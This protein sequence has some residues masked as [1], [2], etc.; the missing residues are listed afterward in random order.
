MHVT[1]SGHRTAQ[2]AEAG[3]AAQYGIMK[4]TSA[5]LR[6]VRVANPRGIDLLF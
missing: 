2:E 3:K 1:G 6:V 4:D 5:G